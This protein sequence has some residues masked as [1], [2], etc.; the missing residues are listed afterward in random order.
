MTQ[1]PA[2]RMILAVGFAGIAA[3]GAIAGAQLKADR[4]KEAAKTVILRESQVRS[5]AVKG[6]SPDSVQTATTHDIG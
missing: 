4:E 6:Y 3:T 2:K 1:S 5:T